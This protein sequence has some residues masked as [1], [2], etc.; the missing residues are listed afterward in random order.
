MVSLLAKETNWALISLIGAMEGRAL[1]PVRMLMYATFFCQ[2]YDSKNSEALADVT[3]CW[4]D[5]PSR[6]LSRGMALVYRIMESPPFLLSARTAP[7]IHYTVPHARADW[8]Y[9]LSPQNS[10]L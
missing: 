10:G 7:A 6:Y 1:F 9:Y 2:V 4:R 3:V 8:F 5:F